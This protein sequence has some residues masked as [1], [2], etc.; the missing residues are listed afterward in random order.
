MCNQHA[1]DNSEV[2]RAM[3]RVVLFW[4]ELGADAF[5]V[6]DALPVRA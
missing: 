2:Q 1:Y 6:D 3:L 4:Q 5:R